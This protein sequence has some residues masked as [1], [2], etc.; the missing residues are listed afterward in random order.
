MGITRAKVDRFLGGVCTF[1]GRL[2]VVAFLAGLSTS[3][4]VE[5]KLLNSFLLSVG[6]LVCLSMWEQRNRMKA[7]GGFSLAWVALKVV[8]WN[9]STR[10]HYDIAFL[11]FLA[12]VLLPR[13]AIRPAWGVPQRRNGTFGKFRRFD[14]HISLVAVEV[15]PATE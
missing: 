3:S 10:W 1:T 7:L 14:D 8:Q 5:D 9:I 11:V 2:V 12:V 6:V 4:L 15:L 13:A